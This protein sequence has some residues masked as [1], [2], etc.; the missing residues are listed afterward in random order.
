VSR[1]RRLGHSSYEKKGRTP[2]SGTPRA[3]PQATTT[4]HYG[5]TLCPRKES[6]ELLRCRFRANRLT[7]AGGSSNRRSL[8]P[9]LFTTCLK[10]LQSDLERMAKRGRMFRLPGFPWI[11][12]GSIGLTRSIHQR[13]LLGRIAPP[14]R[15]GIGRAGVRCL[16]WS[17]GAASFHC[18]KGGLILR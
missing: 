3:T 11:H 2:T 10:R 12:L 6:S 5:T 7:E 1:V 16:R 4:A 14:D 17:L 8:H 13:P 15:Q 9:G 18:R